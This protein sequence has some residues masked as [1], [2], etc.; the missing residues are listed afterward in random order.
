MS[1]RD[2]SSVAD[3]ESGRSKKTVKFAGVKKH[4]L[5][6]DEEE[7]DDEQYNVLDDNDIEGEED[8]IAGMDGETKLTPFN[9]KEEM[10][11]GHFDRE[12]H[13]VWDKTRE[14]SDN[15]LDNI[16]WVKVQETKAGSSRVRTLGEDSSDSEDAGAFNINE[17]YQKML[18]IMKA[19]ETVKK[20]L[21]RLG[22]DTKI[23]SAERWRRK[24]A[25]IV[26]ESAGVI[27]KLT[28]LSN[29]ILTRTGNMDIY[30]ETY[31]AIEKR[32]R[33]TSAPDDALDMYA[34]DFDAKE[35]KKLGVVEPTDGTGDNEAPKLMWEFKL[36]QD[37]TEL[38]G[39][40][41]TEQMH[42]M[43]IDGRFKTGVLVKKVGEDD[44][45]FYNSNRID[46]D[47]YL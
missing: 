13:Y 7:S 45:N 23:S 32:I 44:A 18:E 2:A 33:K 46:F 3:E 15:W 28:E 27:A 30:E 14:I 11:E 20:A 19:G 16:D 17:S 43:S 39:P 36:T 41:T 34:D 25:G 42:K 5:D 22:K 6:S 9:M 10:E 8:G 21:Q 26:D 38:Q 31:E 40:Y 47:L 29:D 1:K 4:T 37:D 35:K 24:K 12:G